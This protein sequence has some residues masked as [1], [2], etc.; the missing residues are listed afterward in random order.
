VAGVGTVPAMPRRPG[1][2]VALREIW[3]GRVWEARPAVVVEDAPDRRSF[4]IPAGTVAQL[5]A[6]ERGEL[7]RLP[8]DEW[9]L[10]EV[11]VTQDVLSFE[12]PE[13]AH[14]V[15]GLFDDGWL[16]GWYVNLQSPLRPSTVGFDY[17]DHV[18]DVLVSADL[19]TWRWKDEEDLEEAVARGIFT[20][21]EAVAIRAEGERAVER[22]LRGEPPF[23]RSWED[24][25]P[26]PWWPRPA[27]PE[28]WDRV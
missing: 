2:V 7:L 5:P 10:R 21:A 15:L 24:W 28:G 6:D 9:R 22:M 14:A 16:S 17:Q 27:F 18:L 20:P 3:R 25:R 26:D 19:R 23:D 13:A 12:D 8:A 1:E 4:F 11:R